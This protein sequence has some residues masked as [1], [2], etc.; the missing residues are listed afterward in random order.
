LTTLQFSVPLILSGLATTV[1]FRAKFISLG[2]LGQMLFG[3]AVGAWLGSR[4]NLPPILHSIVALTGGAVAGAFW[5]WIPAILKVK[6]GSNEVLVT[7]ILNPIAILLVG[8][9]RSSNVVE[10]AQ[11]MPLVQGT[12]LSAGFIIALLSALTIYVYI[13]HTSGGY[14]QR[15]AG[16]APY[17][18]KYGGISADRS[19][20]RAMLISGALAG[21]AGAVEV[22]G[23]YYHFV[24][25]FSAV[26]EFDGIIVGLM[27]LLHPLG[28]VLAG[29][30]LGGL[31]AG[32]IVG[33][34]IQ[35]GVPRELGGLLIAL[36]ILIIA[37]ERLFKGIIK[38][39]LDFLIRLTNRSPNPN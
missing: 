36:T 32:A 9:I 14:E 23:V 11:L 8:F 18:A 30:F 38:K 20:I 31:R 7:L 3:A 34:Q 2:Q 26:T 16:D 10:S 17:F 29:I 22:L 15:M 39:I 13:W 12:K 19:I 35:S 27:G 33:L 1:A 24:S 4:I 25:S 6:A 37:N 5:G 28:V 21:L